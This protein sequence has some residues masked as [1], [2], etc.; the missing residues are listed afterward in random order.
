MKQS[1]LLN[2]LI[3]A[4]VIV[5]DILFWQE[6]MGLNSLLFSSFILGALWVLHPDMRTSKTAIVTGSITLF[7]AC[8]VVWNNSLFSKMVHIMSLLITVGFVQQRALRFLWYGLSLAVLSVIQVPFSWVNMKG[9]SNFSMF[10][11]TPKLQYHL[12]LS[13][14]PLIVVALFYNIYSLANPEFAALGAWFWSG[15]DAFFTNWFNYFSPER[16]LFW[17]SGL[18][19]VTGFLVQQPFLTNWFKKLGV[20][21]HFKLNR[22]WIKRKNVTFSMIGLKSEYR[23][24]IL[25]IA[26]LN[27][28]IFIVNLV[29]IQHVWLSYKEG[30]SPVELSNYVHSG[31]YLLIVSILMAM[32]ILLYFFRRNINFL[33]H[34]EWLKKLSY[35]WIVQNAVLA[36]SVGMRNVHY[37]ETYGLAY[38]RIGVFIFLALTIVGL[39]TMYL[40]IRDKL[41]TY[42]LVQHNTWVLYF[43][44]AFLT[45]IDWDVE[46]TKYNLSTQ[47][48]AHIDMEFLQYEVSNKNLYVLDKHWN[49]IANTLN[50][51]QMKIASDRFYLRKVHFL[52]EQAKY[53]WAS[54]NYADYRNLSHFQQ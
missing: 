10:Q 45:M 24:A 11:Y 32:G 49:E 42:F 43:A 17:V 44:M 46:I 54:W 48:P 30:R 27:V 13:V 26:I 31:T 3:F 8:M 36:L 23:M 6:K 22:T 47:N 1:L 50:E 34:N 2:C 21:H 38:K 18:F 14:V 41:T 35:I 4:G 20:D 9:Q 37:V 12:K 52:K 29:D 51:R 15:I 53:S 16:L 5:F 28:L 40:K 39:Y 25:V 33:P 7:T 19:V